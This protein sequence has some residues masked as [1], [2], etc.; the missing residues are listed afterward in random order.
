M[1]EITFTRK[2]ERTLT[3]VEPLNGH[4]LEQVVQALNDGLACL[5]HRRGANYILMFKE[6]SGLVQIAIYQECQST[7]AADV[8]EGFVGSTH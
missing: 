2:S 6:G 5:E 1:N 3:H 8:D 4:T 7:A